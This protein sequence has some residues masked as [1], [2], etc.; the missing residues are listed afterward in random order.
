[1]NKYDIAI[2]GGGAAGCVAAISASENNK[3]VILIE[4]NNLL[5][6]KILATGNGRCNLTN[7]NVTSDRYHG[8]NP[9]FIDAVIKKFDQRKTMNFFESLGIIL[10]EEDN[11]R[12]FPRNNQAS[13]IRDALEYELKRKKVDI[14]TNSLVR[15]INKNDCCQIILENGQEILANKLII[16]TGG[17]AA[18]QFGSSG[19]GYYWAE[20]LGHKTIA[21]Y[22][23]LVPVET[24][25]N[26]VK[27]VQG[28]KIE[29][30][31]STSFNGKIICQKSGDILFT[32]FGLSGPAIMSQ[33]RFIAPKIDSGKLKIHLD[34][35]A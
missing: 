15:K 9:K 8:A 26:W 4:R 20:K 23:A 21:T 22:P 5:G 1:M 11:G 34:L 17:R 30:K 32:H 25:E 31:I 27:D 28:V 10:K 13:S 3:S 33:A 35:F 14:K 7:T 29:G 6:K 18:H 2:V 16:T 19:D 12:I 24:Q